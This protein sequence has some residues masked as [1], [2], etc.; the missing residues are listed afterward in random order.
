M[1]CLPFESFIHLWSGSILHHLAERYCSCDTQRRARKLGLMATSENEICRYNRNGV[2]EEQKQTNAWHMNNYLV[3]SWTLFDL[4]VCRQ[5]CS[6]FVAA[7]M[8]S[9]LP[10][11][12]QDKEDSVHFCKLGKAPCQKEQWAW[13]DWCYFHHFAH[14]SGAKAHVIPPKRSFTGVIF[15]FRRKQSVESFCF[16]LVLTEQRQR[17]PSQ[18]I[19][20]WTAFSA[21][22]LSTDSMIPKNWLLAWSFLPSLQYICFGFD[23]CV[24]LEEIFIVTLKVL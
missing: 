19:K 3:I 10:L 21:F 1:S 2:I 24:D 15:V 7:S 17:R 22:R 8:T 6:L 16:Y 20:L 9:S 23:C 11:H 18:V 4:P 5:R 13:I 12:P 14:R